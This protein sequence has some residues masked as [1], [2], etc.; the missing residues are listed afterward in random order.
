MDTGVEQFIS[1]F[2]SHKSFGFLVPFPI[3][4]KIQRNVED[5]E[6]F[7]AILSFFDA[8]DC[9][10]PAIYKTM[11][12]FLSVLHDIEWMSMKG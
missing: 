8:F 9:L 4:N 10:C 12:T 2:C 6:F 1:R 11:E 7:D 5:K 3:L